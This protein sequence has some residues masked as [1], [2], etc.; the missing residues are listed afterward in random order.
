MYTH[1]Q[2]TCNYISLYL[3][4]CT[5][6]THTCNYISLYLCTCTHTPHACNHIS[7]YLCTYT[8]IHTLQHDN[9]ESLCQNLLE[10]PFD[11]MS[12]AHIRYI[13]Y[14]CTVILY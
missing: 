14:T 12:A 13:T 9:A 3:C 7:L 11:E 2:H 6:T 1:T 5:H 10:S 8:H 4:T